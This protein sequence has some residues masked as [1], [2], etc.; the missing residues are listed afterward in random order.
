MARSATKLMPKH[1]GRRYNA[2]QWRDSPWALS[3]HP[4]L[5]S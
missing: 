5:P 4:Y 1:D 3:L 2:L